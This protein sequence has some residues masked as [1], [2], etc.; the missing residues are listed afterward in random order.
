M[1]KAFLLLY[2]LKGQH[3]KIMAI[4]SDRFSNLFSFL[5]MLR[6]Q[7]ADLEDLK[8][9]KIKSFHQSV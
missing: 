6:I 4:A 2:L 1:K 8:L 5:R 7:D 9:G 3:P